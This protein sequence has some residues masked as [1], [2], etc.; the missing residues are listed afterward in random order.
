MLATISSGTL[1]GLTGRPI[2]VEVDVAYGGFPSFTIVGLPGKAVDESKD[3]VRTAIINSSLDMPESRITVNL[4]PADLP[5]SGSSFDL[6]I[7]IGILKASQQIPKTAGDRALFVGELSLEGQVKPVPGVI[8]LALLAKEQEISTM[9][10]AQDNAYEASLVGGITVYPVSQ[11]SQLVLHLQGHADIAAYAAPRIEGRNQT[12]SE[13]DFA[14]VR[15]QHQA[16]R[17]LEIAA[18]GFHNVHLKGVP[19]AGKTMLARAFTS[20]LPPLDPEEQ[21]DVIR[22]YSAAGHTLSG[23]DA[24]VARPFR[25]PH[26]TTSRIGLIGGSSTP[27]PGEI[28][29][30][31]RGVLFL[32]EF[33]EFPRSVLEALRQPLEDGVVSVSRAAGTVEFPARFLLIAASNPCPCGYLG[34]PKKRCSCSSGHILRYKKRLSG[35]IL[36]RIDLHVDIAPVNEVELLEKTTATPAERSSNIRERVMKARTKQ[37]HRFAALPIH[38]NAEMSSHQV[39]QLC[40]LQD[41]ARNLLEQAIVRMQLSARATFKVIKVAQTIADLAVQDTI[42]PAHIAESLQYRV[43]E[44]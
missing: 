40:A 39:R 43:Q 18:A 44:S 41:D 7:A 1:L 4:A 35:P 8:S 42:A 12:E 13:L 17:A 34:H 23:W 19:G 24:Q 26:H 28:S 36:D 10:V 14:H 2:E 21:L 25:S 20:I 9:Y 11:L 5:K 33:P 15:G 6:P 37:Q 29:L 32:D 3:R 31:H 27:R 30:A 22:L 38:T 16:K